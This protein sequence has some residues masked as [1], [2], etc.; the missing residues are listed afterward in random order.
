MAAL[1]LIAVLAL[2]SCGGGGS[3]SDQQPP[4]NGSQTPNGGESNTGALPD[5]LISNT[6]PSPGAYES[7]KASLTRLGYPDGDMIHIGQVG[8]ETRS[9]SVSEVD[10]TFDSGDCLACR[11][12]ATR[13]FFD[14]YDPAQWPNQS[15][16]GYW[17]SPSLTGT[18]LAIQRRVQDPPPPSGTGHEHAAVYGILDYGVFWVG[19]RPGETGAFHLEAGA[20]VFRYGPQPEFLPLE[21]QLNA[22]WRGDAFGLRKSTNA[23]V[24]GPTTLTVTSEPLFVGDPNI[25]NQ[26]PFGLNLDVSFGTDDISLPITAEGTHNHFETANADQGYKVRGRFAGAAT[27]GFNNRRP[28]EEAFGVFET[29]HYYGSFGVSRSE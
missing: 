27:A 21:F 24:S 3:N 29:G 13:G 19:R 17:I 20:D 9:E 28:A 14:S 7:Y 16:Y 8:N 10:F 23:F 6:S 12:R 15:E 22:T 2:A 4:G 26:N 5:W 1:P 18:L 25:G 11:P